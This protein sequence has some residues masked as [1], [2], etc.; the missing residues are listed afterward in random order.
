MT[1]DERKNLAVEKE[2]MVHYPYGIA[3]HYDADGMYA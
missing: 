1:A 3:V 2:D